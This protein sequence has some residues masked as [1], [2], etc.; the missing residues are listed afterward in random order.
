M[1]AMVLR[2]PKDVALETVPEPKP[3]AGEVLVR[4]SHSG[5]CGTDL[6]IFHGAIPVHYPR[7]MGHEM[8]GVLAAGGDDRIPNGQRVIVDPCLY[9]GVCHACRAGRTSLCPNGGLVGRDSNGGFAEYLIA[10]RTH[11]F[12]LPDAIDSRMAPLIQVLTTCL[13]GQRMLNMFPGQSAVV[14]GLGVGGQLHVQLAKARGAYPVIGVTRSP[15]KRRLAEQLGADI[16]LSGGV[17]AVKGVMDATGG[18]GADVVIESTGMMPALADSI[19]MAAPGGTLLMFGIVTKPEGALPLYQ[20]YYKEITV[21]NGRAAKG[22]DFPASIDLVARGA[23]KLEPLVTHT[24][25]LAELEAALDMVG[26]D[27]GD[28]MKVILQNN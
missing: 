25:P 8:V 2:A 28:R 11:V 18:R 14:M 5:I 3:G 1:K 7:I 4:V 9:C 16:T 12:A 15:W 27:A 21:V 6:K 26:S 20:L 24:L 22:E 10:P 13:H 23:V 19:T 17:E